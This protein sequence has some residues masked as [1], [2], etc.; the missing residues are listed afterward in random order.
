[1]QRYVLL[2]PSLQCHAR[3]QTITH[4]ANFAVSPASAFSIVDLPAPFGPTTGAHF[5]RLA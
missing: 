5:R 3:F 4:P 2:P 1:L